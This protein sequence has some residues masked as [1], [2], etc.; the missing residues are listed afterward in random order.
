MIKVRVTKKNIVDLYDPETGL[1]PARG[2][3][4]YKP[5]IGDIIL[6]ENPAAKRFVNKVEIVDQD[7]WDAEVAKKEKVAQEAKEKARKAK[8]EA[9][10]RGKAKAKE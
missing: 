2:V 9:K 8:T 6:V 3:M 7:A 4:G 10:A 5:D 1:P